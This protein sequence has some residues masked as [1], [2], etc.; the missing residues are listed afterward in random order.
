[1][2]FLRITW[3]EAMAYLICLIFCAV[4]A[5]AFVAPFLEGK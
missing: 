1:M 2:M 5:W 4:G 3:R